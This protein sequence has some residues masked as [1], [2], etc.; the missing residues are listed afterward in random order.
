MN[1]VDGY[2]VVTSCLDVD[3]ERSRGVKGKSTE[4]SVKGLAE[5]HV[6]SARSRGA[7]DLLLLFL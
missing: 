1:I 2:V 6:G 3:P 4:L 5:S 7:I